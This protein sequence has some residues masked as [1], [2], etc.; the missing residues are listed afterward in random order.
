[1]SAV[2][3]KG[4]GK[5]LGALFSDIGINVNVPAFEKNPEAKT[6]KAD[7]VFYIGVHDIKPNA[8][9]P[10]K[11]FKEETID[12]LA[13]S[14]RTHGVIQPI[15]VRKAEN[16]YELVAGERRWR[17]ARKAG[18]KT[19]PGLI[20]EMNEEQNVFF[21]LIENM[22]REDLNPIEEAE[23]IRQIMDSFGLTQ[24]E[25]SANIGKSR[26]YIANALRLLRLPQEVRRFLADG[27]LSGGHG[28]AIAAVEGEERQI[29]LAKFVA[30][31]SCSVRETES[32]AHNGNFGLTK[33]KAR[34][35]RKNPDIASAEEE[36][37]TILGTKVAINGNSGEGIIEVH[38]YSRDELD[39]LIELLRLLR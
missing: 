16:G 21:A 1:M 6:V 9:Q 26:P 34:P 20:R 11:Y 14:I 22:Q 24:E 2:K 31:K 35:R 38:Y 3:T 23:A 10:R 36:L 37:R 28:K 8:R 18:L 33:K 13:E 15:I 17:A 32:Y 19:I 27:T 4:L 25:V 39:G 5:G 7:G 30:S 29:A 12:E